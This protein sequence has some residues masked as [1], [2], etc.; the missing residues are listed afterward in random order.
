MRGLPVRRIAS[1]ALCATLVLGIAGPAA[2]AADHDPSRERTASTSQAPVADAEALLAQS[3]ALSDLG[4]VLDPVTKMLDTV[5][6]AGEGQIS[7]EEATKLG[8]A[9]KA[10]IAKLAMAAPSAPAAP[11]APTAPST[12]TSPIVTLPATASPIKNDNKASAAEVK[13]DALD[14]L[15]KAIDALIEAI[16]SGLVD[17]VVPSAT[18]VVTGLVNVLTTTLLGSGLPAPTVAGLPP[19]PALPASVPQSPAAV[20]ETPALPEEPP[21]VPAATPAQPQ[22]TPALPET[23]A[24]VPAAP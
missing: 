18:A 21:A 9:A 5:L 13:A 16:T 19:L 10:A 15:Q 11:E 24:A 17:Q 6:K 23:P 12:S 20:P 14:E 3:K 4:V 1:T 8:D 7:A 22:V 2:M